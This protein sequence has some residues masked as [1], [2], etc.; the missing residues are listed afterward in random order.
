MR[1]LSLVFLLLS[2][3][4]S[5]QTFPDYDSLTINDKADLLTDAE[6]RLLD[7]QLSE[8]RAET[9]VEMTILTLD[10]QETYAPNLSLEAFATGLFNDWGIGDASR[11][12]G[13]LVLV[14]KED[15]AM[16]LELGAGYGRE[17][18]TV[19]QRVVDRNFLPFFRDDEFAKGIREGTGATIR[20][21]VNPFRAGEEPAESGGNWFFVGLVAVLFGAKVLPFGNIFARFRKCPSCGQRGMRQTHRT[22]RPASTSSS[23]SGVAE[24]YCLHCDYREEHSIIIPRISRGLGVGGFGG[25]R[26]GGGGASGRF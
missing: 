13:V 12:D 18:D 15:R 20:E 6:E 21:I 2:N 11:N 19:A 9:G 4:L 14:L 26:S 7:N 25:G 17:W 23:G 10:T 3:P 1:T 5:A 8:L 22:I 16:R 24:V